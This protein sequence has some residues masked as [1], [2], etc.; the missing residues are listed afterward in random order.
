MRT[1]SFRPDALRTLLLRNKIATLDELKQALGT[2]VDVTVFRKLKPLDYLT[3]Y[4]HRGRYYTL[5]EIALF[6]DHGLWSRVEVWFSRF[7][8]LLATAEAFVNRSPRGY[9]ADE[10]APAL[11]VQVQDALH[12]LAQQGRVTRQ[13]VAGRYL[14]MAVDQTVQRRQLLARRTVEFLPTV[15][16]ASVLD[17]PAEEVKAAILLFYSLLDEQQRRLYAGLESLKLGRGGDRQLADFL[18]LDPHT[19]ARGRQQLLAQDVEVD[20]ARKAGAGRKRVEKKTPEIV[21]AIEI[22]LE[23]DTAGDPITGLKWT[24]RTTEKIAEVLQQIDI[25][26]SANTVARLLYQMNFSLRVNRKQIAT[27]SSPYRDQQF[28]HISSLRTRFQ[29]QGLPLISV[30]SKKRELIG[31]FKNAGAKWDRSPVLVN[32]HDF[33]S[34]ASGVGIS[35]GIYDPPHNHGTVCVGISHDTPAFAAHSVATWWKREGSRRYGR[36]PKLLVLADSGGSNSCTSWAW[37]TEIQTQVCNTFGIAVTIAHYPTGASKWNPIEHRLF[38][39]ISKNWAAEPLDSYEKMLKFIRTT[40]TKTG[41]VVTAYLDRNDYPTGLK[42]DP[43]LVSSL[44]LRRDKLLPQWNYTIA[45]N[46]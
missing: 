39:E 27:N 16:D 29:R 20:R 32:D 44:C 35:Y 25:P 43:Q 34:D 42:P 38:S 41:L 1:L 40:S 22:L 31:N 30:D 7:G 33:R 11:H 46:L 3:S 5:R 18:D 26:V 23:H 4:S 10:L 21:D 45:P 24:R 9:F 15:V 19:V 17:V 37:K 8:T 12:Q 28:Q 36:T 14:Y 6:D 2:P 13:I